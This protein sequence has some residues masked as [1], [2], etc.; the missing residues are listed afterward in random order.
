VRLHFYRVEIS[1]EPEGLE[2]Q[3]LLWAD[4]DE[5]AGL[6]FPEADRAFLETLG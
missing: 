1:G 5:L 6:D 3:P 4:R 2:G